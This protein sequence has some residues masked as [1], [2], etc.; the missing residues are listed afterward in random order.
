MSLAPTCLFLSSLQASSEQT[1]H[2][3]SGGTPRWMQSF[4]AKRLVDEATMIMIVE[5]S[6][7][8]EAVVGRVDPKVVLES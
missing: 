6:M 3:G 1:L 5:V 2:P 7:L 4:C 8:C